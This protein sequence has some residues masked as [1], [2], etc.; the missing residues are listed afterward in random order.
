MKRKHCPGTAEQIFN[1]GG[2]GGGEKQTPEVGASMEG[3]R[4]YF[5]RKF[6]NLE[7]WKC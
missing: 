5:P 2:G 3:L 4:A 6:S 1:G 7:T